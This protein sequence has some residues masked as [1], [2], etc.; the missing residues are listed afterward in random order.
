MKSYKFHITADFVQSHPDLFKYRKAEQVFAHD[1]L[2]AK[3]VLKIIPKR[4]T[5]N[6][7]TGLRILLTPLVIWLIVAGNLAAGVILFLFA[8]FTDAVDGSLAR[9]RNR[10][11]KFGMLLDP[12]ADKLLIGTVVLLLVFQ[13][14]HYSLGIAVLGIEIIFIMVAII[15]K[16]KFHT[17]KAA[18]LWGKIKMLLQVLAIFFTLAA[19]VFEAPILLT[20]AAWTFGV[21]IGFAIVSLFTH[22]V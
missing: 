6:Q 14:F 9:T 16:L 3:T 10:I 21:A 2:L 4:I 12:L 22:G 13:H 8:A 5:P 15:A 1:R 20:I 7:I 19:L 11:T 17:V 18:N